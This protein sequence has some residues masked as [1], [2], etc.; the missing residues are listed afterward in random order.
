MEALASTREASTATK[1]DGSGYLSYDAFVQA[2][3]FLLHLAKQSAR[4]VVGCAS[5]P[6]GDE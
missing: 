2:Q 5:N 3:L 1:D 6:P 4:I